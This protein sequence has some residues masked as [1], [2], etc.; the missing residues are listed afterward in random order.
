MVNF[1]HV[2]IYRRRRRRRSEAKKK[3]KTRCLKP[4][5]DRAFISFFRDERG[6]KEGLR[7]KRVG[8]YIPAHAR[9]GPQEVLI[10]TIY[11][12]RCNNTG[13]RHTHC[14]HHGLSA[15]YTR[16]ELNVSLFFLFFL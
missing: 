15:S 3:K 1:S 9:Y 6:G 14:D 16:V 8:I 4:R 7:E 13:S 12:I 5:R 10:S 2:F 11:P